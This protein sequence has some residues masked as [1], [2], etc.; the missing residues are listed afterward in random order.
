MENRRNKT[1]NRTWEE[2]MGYRICYLSH[3]SW[4]RTQKKGQEKF[5]AP[6]VRYLSQ[7]TAR[8]SCTNAIYTS[9][10]RVFRW[11]VRTTNKNRKY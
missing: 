8:L 4:T 1:D 6:Y 10:F 3:P 9:K 5:A 2:K 11:T 7:S